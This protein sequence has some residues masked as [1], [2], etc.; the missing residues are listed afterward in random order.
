MILLMIEK[1]FSWIMIMQ[2]RTSAETYF[3][4]VLEKRGWCSIMIHLDHKMLLVMDLVKDFKL[5][6][7][8]DFTCLT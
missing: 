4:R 5:I 2:T 7:N 8:N 6:T 1:T 3:L